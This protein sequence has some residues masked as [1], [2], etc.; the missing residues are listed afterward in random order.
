MIFAACWQSVSRRISQSSGYATGSA[1]LRLSD[2]NRAFTYFEIWEVS[3]STSGCW[4]IARFNV[5][6]M[7]RTRR[8]H[9]SCHVA[10]NEP[11]EC[12][13]RRR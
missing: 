9:L 4:V 12:Q 1:S 11:R 13:R 6:V 5:R 8:V 2:S 3:V 10:E 7:Q